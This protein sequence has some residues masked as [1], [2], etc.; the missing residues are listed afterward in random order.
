MRAMLAPPPPSGHRTAMAASV[1]S[2]VFLALA[3]Q[4]GG[5]ADADGLREERP[6]EV[7]P[8]PAVDPVEARDVATLN[9]F[10]SRLSVGERLADTDVE[11]LIALTRSPAPRARALAAAVLAWLEPGVALQPLLLLAS[12]DDDRVRAA[13]AGSLVALSRRLPP[14][15]RPKVIASGLGFLDDPSDEVACVGAELLANLRPEG[16][17]D[18]FASRAG[19]ASDVRYACYA[20]FGG[21]PVRP[22]TLPRLPETRDT[23]SGD[24]P[25]R[26][27]PVPQAE[28]QP[29]WIFYAT[30]A[31]AGALIGGAVPAMVVP[32]RDVLVYDDT[33]TR[34]SREELSFGTQLIAVAMGGAALGG[35]AWGVQEWA[36]PIDATESF[37]IAGSTGAGTM[38]GAGLG[39]M[40]STDSSTLA[41]G[42]AAGTALGLAAGTT[43]AVVGELD[44]HDNALVATSMAMGGLGSVLLTFAA[45]PVAQTTLG[46]VGRTDF[47]LGAAMAGAGLGGL[48]A[49][50]AAPFLDVNAARSGAIAG[51]GLLGGG[52]LTGLGFL[53]VPKELET[54]SRIAAGLGLAGQVAG[55]VAAG[56]LVPDSWLDA[57]DDVIQGAAV[58]VSPREA[59]LGLPVPVVFVP[60][61]GQQH[62]PVGVMLLSGRL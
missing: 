46:D 47:G 50:A 21:L 9:T 22:V 20:R 11:T 4:A 49:T 18:A 35:V 41:G 55:A 7:I 1:F 5:T 2:A 27:D 25:Q 16:I 13:V 53:I 31:A 45:V 39:F 30:A 10:E 42:L 24:S 15:T 62:P 44:H 32:G 6:V 40:L 37:T 51:G 29:P 52:L 59:R 58:E 43:S 34:L 38:L 3:A 28:V 48:V 23:D 8:P 14:E 56:L 60:L 12:D 54:S 57:A 33:Q 17:S 19:N 61:P 36:G 26:P